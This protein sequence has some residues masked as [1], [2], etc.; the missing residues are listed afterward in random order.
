MKKSG[1]NGVRHESGDNRHQ[2]A[3]LS[4]ENGNNGGINEMKKSSEVI[5]EGRKQRKWRRNEW[6]K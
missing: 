5:I 2:R 3:A 1:G 6:R 4:A